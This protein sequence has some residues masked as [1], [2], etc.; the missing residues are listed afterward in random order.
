MFFS[1]SSFVPENEFGLARRVRPSRSA[2]ACSFSMLRLNL[3]LK[4]TRFVPIS[5]AASIYLF[6]PS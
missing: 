6:K 1:L 3:V 4:L 2:S 5:A